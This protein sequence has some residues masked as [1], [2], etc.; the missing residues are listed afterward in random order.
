[1]LKKFLELL[2]RKGQVL[3]IIRHIRTLNYWYVVY[4]PQYNNQFGIP[5][6][7]LFFNVYY[8]SKIAFKY[9]FRTIIIGKD[10]STGDFYYL[11]RLIKTLT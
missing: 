2:N 11:L 4:T 3:L 10:N 6:K 1:M 9:G 8:F 7:Y 5:V